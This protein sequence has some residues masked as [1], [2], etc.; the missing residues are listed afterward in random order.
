MALSHHLL[1]AETF[2]WRLVL[3]PH[4][5]A[6]MNTAAILAQTALLFSFLREAEMKQASAAAACILS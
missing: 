5:T 4:A 6:N 2:H 1:G 3:G